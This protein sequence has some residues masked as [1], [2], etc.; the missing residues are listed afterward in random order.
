MTLRYGTLM[1]EEATIMIERQCV[2]CGKAFTL[3]YPSD[4]TRPGRGQ[5]CSLSCRASAQNVGP[6]LSAR[7]RITKT[8]IV[9]GED[10]E[11]GGRAG[12]AEKT[13]CS[14]AC[15][16][17][18]RYRTGKKCAELAP[19]DAAYLAGFWDGEGSFMIHGRNNQGGSIGFR[20]AVI[21][22]KELVIRWVKDVT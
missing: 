18:S 1:V 17:I 22:S 12:S 5:F 13:I 10:F 20:A 16:R 11:T 21:G 7:R 19:L 3:R 14:M 6:H 9:C 4:L 15:Q 2:H 8:C